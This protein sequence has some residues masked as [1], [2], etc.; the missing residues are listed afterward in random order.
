MMIKKMTKGLSVSLVQQR[1][2]DYCDDVN[3]VGEKISDLILIEE[4][5]SNFEDISGAILSRSQKSRVMGLGPWMGRQ[6]WPHDWQY[7]KDF[8][9]S[10]HSQLQAD[11]ATILGGMFDWI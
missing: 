6:Q 2:A 1:D 4:I 7:D 5:F 10:N 11:F 8:R 9:I 3:F